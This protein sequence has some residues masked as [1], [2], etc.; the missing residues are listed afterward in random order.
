MN[1]RK[2]LIKNSSKHL[3]KHLV[4]IPHYEFMYRDIVY[5]LSIQ[6]CKYEYIREF[7]ELH[8]LYYESRRL[9]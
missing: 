1:L 4:K 6:N 9:L 3:R 5:Q 7:E 2:Y 8:D